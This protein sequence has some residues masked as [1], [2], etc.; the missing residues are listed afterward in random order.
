MYLLTLIVDLKI[1][2]ESQIATLN[3]EEQIDKR[4]NLWPS[5]VVIGNDVWF[6]SNVTLVPGVTIGSVATK[7]VAANTVVGGVLAKYI[8]DVK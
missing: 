2:E 8:R 3:H 6:G 5:P 7:Y 4:G 1:K